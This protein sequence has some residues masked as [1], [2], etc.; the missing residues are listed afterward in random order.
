MLRLGT[1]RRRA[2]ERRKKRNDWGG[3]WDYIADGAQQDT[4]P[5]LRLPL[6]VTPFLLPNFVLRR[7]FLFLLLLARRRLTCRAME[8]EEERMVVPPFLRLPHHS[9]SSCVSLISRSYLEKNG[10]RSFFLSLLPPFLFLLLLLLL[11]LPLHQ[12]L[13]LLPLHQLLLHKS[14]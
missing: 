1:T 5:P 8:C 7:L 3:V 12:L 9:A 13:L 14:H 11:L 4:R 6:L 10:P 2:R